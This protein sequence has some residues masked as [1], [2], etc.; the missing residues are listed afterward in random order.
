[1]TCLDTK[2]KQKFNFKLLKEINKSLSNSSSKYDNFIFVDDFNA[3]PTES[4]IISE[5]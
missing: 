5:T 4:A 2:S 1:M 3:E